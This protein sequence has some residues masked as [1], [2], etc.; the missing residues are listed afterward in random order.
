MTPSVVI[1]SIQWRVRSRV[2]PWRNLWSGWLTIPYQVSSFSFVWVLFSS[3]ELTHHEINDRSRVCPG[4]LSHL[5]FFHRRD[6][7]SRVSNVKMS[8]LSF[9]PLP[10]PFLSYLF[11]PAHS[12]FGL[13]RLWPRQS[14]HFT[15]RRSLFR[16]ETSAP[17]C[18]FLLPPF[19][20]PSTF[21]CL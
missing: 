5:P 16:W 21:G 3:L 6:G 4:F 2:A 7:S 14:W 12:S 18:L 1:F 17:L 11:P 19:L 10:L 9:L 8:V 13:Q 20:K 15:K